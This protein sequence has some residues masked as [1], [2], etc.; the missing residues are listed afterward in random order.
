[1]AVSL[2]PLAWAFDL[3]LY[4]SGT[5]GFKLLP[6][7]VVAAPDLPVPGLAGFANYQ[8]P[9]IRLFLQIEGPIS[10]LPPYLFGFRARQC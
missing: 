1:M 8:Q 2:E 5:S 10:H 6:A 4:Q 9:S 3:P 7:V